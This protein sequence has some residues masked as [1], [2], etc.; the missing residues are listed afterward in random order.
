[1][2]EPK[3]SLELYKL[4][5]KIEHRFKVKGIIHIPADHVFDPSGIPA[6]IEDVQLAYVDWATE[7]TA[8]GYRAE[9]YHIYESDMRKLDTLINA[10]KLEERILYVLAMYPWVSP[11][12]IITDVL[13]VDEDVNTLVNRIID[14]AELARIIRK[15]NKEDRDTLINVYGIDPVD[16]VSN[17]YSDIEVIATLDGKQE[18]HWY[19]KPE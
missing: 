18:L 4:A 19:K 10:L 12:K 16:V 7:C 2:T 1:M 6:F 17:D 8:C 13:G 9:Q 14:S 11:C 3:I 15:N 5:K